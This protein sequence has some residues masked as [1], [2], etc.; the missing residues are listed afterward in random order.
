M[1]QLAD[2]FERPISVADAAAELAAIEAELARRHL[3][4][5]T[6]YTWPG[7]EENWHHRLVGDAL[8]RVLAGK[9]RRLII[10]E[11]P[12]NGKSEQVSRRFPAYALGKNPDLRIIAT[13]YGDT[14][15]GDMSRD[16]QKIMSTPEYRTLFP[17]TRLGEAKDPEKRTQGQFDVVGRKGY[18]IG[19]AL[20]GGITGKT[21]DIGIIDD[22]IKNRAE[23]ESPAFRER[24]WDDYKSAFVTR[25]FGTTGAIIICVTRWHEDDLVGR[26]LELAAK[27]PTADQWEVISL[28]ALAS[29][30]VELHQDDPRKSGSNDP[31]WPDKYPIEELAR[32]RAGMGEYDWAALYQQVPAPS[33]GGLFKE[34]WFAGKIVDAAPTLMRKARGWDTAGTENDGDWTCGVKI[35]EEFIVSDPKT[36][37]TASTGRFFV[38][39]VQRKQ[40]G[41]DSVDKLMR[42]ITELDGHDC[43]QREEKEGGSAGGAVTAARLKT[44]KGYDYREVIISGSKVTRSKPFRAQCEGGNVYL[45]RADWNVAY[46]KELCGFPTALHDDQVDGS[47][48]AFNAVLLE[49]PPMADNWLVV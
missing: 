5:F 30:K 44:L 26:L 32:R 33:G 13:S 46:I 17:N 29:A 48:C 8:D 20:H 16:V 7:Y 43:A 49:E 24:V 28:P 36:G 42:L 21:S 4:D 19:C 23:A 14:L 15:A 38:L 25:Q 22:P 39:D 35:G 12:Q 47:S 37:E 27:D 2:V 6:K 45:L 3:L 18:Y 1:G 34:E 9:C 41:P 10:L 40:F 11:P 31:L